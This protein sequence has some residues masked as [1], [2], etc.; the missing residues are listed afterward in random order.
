MTE[1]NERPAADVL[2]LATAALR[3]MSIPDGP[4]PQLAAATVAALHSASIRPDVLRLTERKRKMFRLMRYSG[5]AAAV[6]LLAVLAGWLFLMD[7]TALPAF[8][9][10]IVKIKNAKSVTFVT[11]MPTV[12]QGSRRGILQQKWYVQGDKYRMELSSAQEDIPV[13]PDAP[14]V[15]LAII[16]DAK[17]K[18]AL[19]LDFVA[20]TARCIEADD[21]QW[22]EMVQELAN[23]IEKLRQLKNEDAERIGDEELNGRKTQVFRLKKADIFLGLRLSKDETAKLWVDSKSG[24]P[25]RI[26]AGDPSDKDKP[27]IV[28]EQFTWNEALD[29]DLFKLEVPK[30]FTLKDK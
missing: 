10:M 22:Q 26:A 2:D 30:G 20:K 3:N 9:D 18:K 14:P 19:Q 5:A 28:F 8:A 13:P 23:P 24:L 29:P 12:V 16:A 25:V 1:R 17:Q 11:K 7:R 15:L 6:A 27:F 21:R 4:P